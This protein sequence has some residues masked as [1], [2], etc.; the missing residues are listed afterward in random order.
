[1]DYVNLDGLNGKDNMGGLEVDLLLAPESWFTEIKGYKTTTLAGDSVTIDGAHTF[2]VGKGFVKMYTTLDT[3]KLMAEGVGER[4]GRGKKINVE[5]FHP[6]T[7]KEAAEFDRQAK[8][9]RFIGLVRDPNLPAGTYIQVGIKGLPAEI[10]G[11]YDSATLSSGRKGF[12]FTMEAYANGLTFYEGTVT[13][14]S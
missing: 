2:P 4:D 14:K 13:L 12:T 7:A 8:N 9:D 10:V 5:V 1:M 11:K 3:G 6:G